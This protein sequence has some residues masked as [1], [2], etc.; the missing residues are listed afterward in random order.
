MTENAHELTVAQLVAG[1]L[2]GDPRSWDEILLRYGG[3]VRAVIAACRMQAA[4]NED[5][6][7]NT[8]L[9]AVERL[10]TLRDPECLAAWLIT[11]ARRECL[12][13]LTRARRERPDSDA[14]DGLVERTPGPEAMA[15]RAEARG[16][17]RRAVDGLPAKRRHLVEVL[18]SEQDHDYRSASSVTG[19]PVGSVGPTRMR[20]LSSLRETLERAG[21]DSADAVPA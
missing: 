5:A 14:A 6:V 21:F 15:L 1:A 19:M 7:Q 11:I 4:D 16:A 9:R 17:V 18:Y 12:A 2:N 3:L 13:L 8:W 10:H 20:I